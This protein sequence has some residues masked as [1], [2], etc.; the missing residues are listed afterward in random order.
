MAEDVHLSTVTD[1]ASEEMSSEES[2]VFTSSLDKR[3]SIEAYND[4][5]L[6][7]PEECE[8]QDHSSQ[9]ERQLTKETTTEV[10]LG[11]SKNSNGSLSS[12]HQ[13]GA[14]CNDT[15]GLGTGS[16]S[17]TTSQQTERTTKSCVLSNDL[18]DVSGAREGEP[19]EDSLEPVGRETVKESISEQRAKQSTRNSLSSVCK[20]QPS[21]DVVPCEQESTS[22]ERGSGMLVSG[23]SLVL[24]RNSL[25][26]FCSH[27]R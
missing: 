27:Q 15:S 2:E 16:C 8:E 11:H 12:Q 10:V 5:D 4:K 1:G 19:L 26:S 3:A 20:S 7:L 13:E 18:Q 24:P 9:Q 17:Q 25:V 22:S 14:C 6:T 21:S 23:F